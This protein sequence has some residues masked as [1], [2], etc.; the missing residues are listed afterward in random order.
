VPATLN[1]TLKLLKRLTYVPRV[2]LTGQLKR[3]EA[4]KQEI[5]PGVEHRQH[6]RSSYRF[7]P[8]DHIGW[9]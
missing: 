1:A 6:R 4:A 7:L 8:G 9:P 2:I 5:L 3:D